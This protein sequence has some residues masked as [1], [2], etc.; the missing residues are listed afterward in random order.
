MENKAMSN[1]IV[2]KAAKPFDAAQYLDSDEAREAFLQDAMETK[3][4][5]FIAHA[6]TVVARAKELEAQAVMARKARVGSGR[7]TW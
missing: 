6:K 2:K 4:P 1:N 5:A 7:A 3:D